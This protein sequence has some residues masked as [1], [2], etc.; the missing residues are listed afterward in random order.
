MVLNSDHDLTE[1]MNKL[2]S[3]VDREKLGLL[4]QG[5]LIKIIQVCIFESSISYSSKN[6]FNTAEDISKFYKVEKR[7]IEREIVHNL[8]LQGAS[9]TV[10]KI[11]K[12]SDK[13]YS[14]NPAFG[15]IDPSGTT[16]LVIKRVANDN[17]E[18]D[19]PCSDKFLIKAY[20]SNKLTYM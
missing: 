7:Q 11:N 10:D 9:T 18:I 3:T 4:I 14:A 8:F 1:I 19:Q 17:F 13:L 2:G 5:L 6:L 16:Q 12:S 20:I 15:F